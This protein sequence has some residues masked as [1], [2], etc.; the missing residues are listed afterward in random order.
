MK[1]GSS[2][3]YPGDT[4]PPRAGLCPTCLRGAHASAAVSPDRRRLAAWCPHW[5][6]LAAFTVKDGAASDW[7][8]EFGVT[9]VELLARMAEARRCGSDLRIH[10]FPTVQ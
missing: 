7:E 9:R 3:R 4:E 2:I 6:T 10:Y 1:P 8:F 5:L